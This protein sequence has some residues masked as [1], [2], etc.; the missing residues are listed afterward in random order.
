MNLVI[1]SHPELTTTVPDQTFYTLFEQ[2]L[3]DYLRECPVHASQLGNH[4]YD[5]QLGTFTREGRENRTKSQRQMLKRL[6]EE[7]EWGDLSPSARI[8]H[9]IL[10]HDLE[11]RIWLAENIRDFEEDPRSYNLYLTDSV[12]T[13]LTQSSLPHEENIS[14]AIARIRRLPE[15]IA[16]ARRSLTSPPLPVLETSISQNRGVISFY[17]KGLYSLIGNSPQLAEVKEAAEHLVSHLSD[18]QDFLEN[19]VRARATDQWR[20]GK[21]KFKHKLQLSLNADLTADDVL[22]QAESEFERVTGEMYVNARQLWAGYYEDLALPPDD[23]EGRHQ[24]ITRVLQAVGQEHG[25]PEGL[26]SDA[27][28]TVEKLKKFI[29]SKDILRLP[30]PDQCEL[31][32]MPEFHRGNSLAYIQPAPPLDPDNKTIYAISP[33]PA[34]WSDQQV[35]SFLQEYNRHM[36]QILT[37]HEAYPGHYVQLA[38]HNRETS[39]VRRLLL[40]G[41]FIEGWAV[42]TEQMMLDQGY[43]EGDL[44]LRLTQLKFY[45]R[46]VANAILDHRMH[47]SSLSDE[48]ALDFL[49]NRS[50]QSEGEALLK[51]ARSK[52]STVQLSTYFVGRMALY[53][54]RRD[55]QR[56]Q[57][58]DFELGRYHEAVLAHGS[59]PVKYLG[60]LVRRRLEDPR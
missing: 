26:L 16:E 11:E 15:V 52:Q 54:L 22:R 49:M 38:Y 21:E 8:D 50:F 51:I 5:D 18:Y 55:I 39:P 53:E 12:Y 37:I 14:N 33:P 10:C 34:N 25:A 20:L 27:R 23:L 56:E 36:L 40:S 45:L 47:C 29:S 44:S 46:A 59:L 42:Y 31:T 13:L 28:S 6:K 30:E 1:N 3:E 32:E 17:Q 9:E 48:E 58:P 7:V 57:G 35:E 19:D 41:V 43:G 60:E 2:Y 24:T 4:R